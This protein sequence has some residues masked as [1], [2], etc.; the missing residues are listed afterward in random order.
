MKT[1]WE[2]TFLYWRVML[3]RIYKAL[4]LA[5]AFATLNPPETPES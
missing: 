1:D 2:L 5:T 3:P 4:A